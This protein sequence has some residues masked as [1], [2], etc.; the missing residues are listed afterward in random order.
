MEKNVMGNDK[1]IGFRLQDGIL[2]HSA[3]KSVS[4]HQ[5]NCGLWIISGVASLRSECNG[6]LRTRQRKY[7]FYSLSHLYDGRGKYWNK[8]NGAREIPT[9]AAVIVTPGTIHR[10]GGWGDEP[11]VEDYICFAGPIADG[12]KRAGIIK[13]G[14]SHFGLERRLLPIVELAR[15]PSNDAQTQAA[16]MLQNLLFD[17]HKHGRESTEPGSIDNIIDEIRS[18]PEIWWTVKELADMCNTSVSQFRRKFKKNTGML[19]KEYIEELKLRHSADMLLA[20]NLSVKK[21][22]KRFGYRDPFHFS[23][24]FKHRFGVSPEHYRSSDGSIIT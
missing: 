11:Y 15:D 2:I 4:E 10:Y 9:G 17:I 7:E 20:S 22:A 3:H 13:D 1:I 5:I 14:F 8:N 12:W 24:R 16:L 23:R 19:P 18:N 21:I 6:F